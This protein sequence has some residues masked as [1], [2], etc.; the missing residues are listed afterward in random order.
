MWIVQ[1]VSDLMRPCMS[2]EGD[3]LPGRLRL[4]DYD[5]D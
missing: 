1:E 3:A 2:N 4:P 5:A